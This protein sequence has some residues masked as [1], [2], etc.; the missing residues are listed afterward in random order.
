MNRSIFISN[1]GCAKNQVDAETL[2]ELLRHQGWTVVSEASDAD[3]IF[4][5]SCGFIEDAKTESIDTVLDYCAR[6]P[7][8]AVVLGGCMA[9][10]YAA[11]L[12]TELPEVRAIVGNRDLYALAGR[13]GALVDGESRV[14]V[15][16]GGSTAETAPRRSR[17][18]SMPGSAYVKIAEG[19]DKGCTF[20]AIPAIRGRRRSR[21]PG[22]IAA[23]IRELFDRGILEVTLVAQDLGSYGGDIGSGLPELLRLIGPIDPDRWIRMLYLYPESITDELLSIVAEHPSILPY[24]DIPFQHADPTVLGRMGREGTGEDALRTVERIREALPE[25]VIRSSLMVGFPGE[26]DEQFARLE[27]FV[28]K[29]QIDWLGIFEFSPEEGTAAADLNKG[30]ARVSKA[31]RS[32]RRRTI[33]NT[34]IEIAARRLKR[35]VGTR[36]RILVEEPFED[37]PLALGRAYAH[38]PEVDGA[39]VVHGPPAPGGTFQECRI[40]GV[41]GLDLQ[42]VPEAT[43]AV[44]TP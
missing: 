23:E 15:P 28:R 42:A 37:E 32:D 4:V 44:P 26:S 33:E 39:V 6:F 29:A 1:L 24:F 36:Q 22:E 18:L 31:A 9:Q 21:S 13:L 10:R 19:C 2:I 11:E 20:C 34:Q 8:T 17:L 12:D 38:A 43:G 14:F 7:E 30:S 35:F 3:T 25:A 27:T 5:N 40:F 41:A 16:D